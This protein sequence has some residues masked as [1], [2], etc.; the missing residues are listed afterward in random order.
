MY[1][2]IKKQFKEAIIPTRGTDYSA[3]LDLYMPEA[4]KGKLLAF[5]QRIDKTYPIPGS[6][7]VNTEVGQIVLSPQLPTRINTGISIEIP[8]GYYGAVRG[9]S[10]LG[11]KGVM[12]MHGTIDS[13][14]RGP[15]YIVLTNLLGSIYVLHPKDKIAQLVIQPY[16]HCVPKEVDEL[17]ETK[18]G[19]G[20]FGSTGK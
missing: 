5:S 16:Q 6:T 12:C 11:F 14:Y 1:L 4:V 3:G 19:V 7:W 13:D 17:T 18:R 10:S 8:H 20:G 9:R 15:L 2:K